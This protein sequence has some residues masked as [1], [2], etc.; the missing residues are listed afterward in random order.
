MIKDES[1][2]KKN[3]SNDE[4]KSFWKKKLF[5]LFFSIII[6]KSLNISTYLC[7]YVWELKY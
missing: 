2:D 3:E 5:I 4:Y 7:N 6:Y 1:N